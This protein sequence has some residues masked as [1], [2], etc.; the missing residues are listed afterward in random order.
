VVVF[1]IITAAMLEE[2]SV[3]L[4]LVIAMFVGVTALVIVN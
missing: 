2:E 4:A 3:I 1:V